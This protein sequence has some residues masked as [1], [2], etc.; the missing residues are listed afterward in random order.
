MSFSDKL[1]NVS[2]FNDNQVFIQIVG[3]QKQFFEAALSGKYT[4]LFYGG[5]VGGMKTVTL[6]MLLCLLCK[7]Y[8]GSRWLVVRK[9]RPVL[10]RNT[11]PSFWKFC[12]KPFFHP[13]RY[14]GQEMKATA[15]NGSQIIFMSENISKDPEL[16]AFDG[17]EING[18]LI[19]EAQ[20]TSEALDL[21]LT[22][23]IGR[24]SIDPMPPLFH[25]YSANPTQNWI[26]QV[27]YTPFTNGK[28]PDNYYFLQALPGDNPFLPEAY[29]KA[30]EELKVR[31][32]NLY[33][34]R[35]QGSWDAEDEFQQLVSWE[36]IWKCESLIEFDEGEETYRSMG[37]DVGRFGSDPSVWYILEG[38][39]KKGFN[40]IHTEKY[41]KTSGPQVESKT[42][43]LIV[44]YEIAHHR[45]WLDIVGLGGF[46]YDHIVEDGYDIQAFSGG[47]HGDELENTDVDQKYL[48]HNLNSEAGWQVKIM[49]E[50]GK[51]GG[52]DSQLLRDD[53]AVYRYDIKGEK[54]IHLW[55][56][57]IIKKKL[58]RSPDDGDAFKYA[59][60]GAIYDEVGLMPG[61]IIV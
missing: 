56:K 26:K 35:V 59:V 57:D 50:D 13:S 43:E 37:V 14:N 7:V 41:D 16:T 32:P 25:F 36:D 9:D 11:L 33:R 24:W 52:L 18:A 38:N 53:I 17:L 30:L 3:K 23:R 12:P 10:V 45:V 34:K 54:T 2:E 39:S 40:I 22:D 20:E 47:S 28:L 15:A 29:I 1:T 51:I 42:K 4:H 31:A 5:A 61:I 58:H 48:F 60:W 6:L 44:E 19:E 49:M 46:A 21:K 27:F 8:P 55:P